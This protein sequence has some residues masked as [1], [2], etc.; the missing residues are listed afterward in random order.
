[1]ACEFQVR[2][3][4]S[5]AENDTEAALAALDAV[6]TI[7]DRLT[8]YRSESEVQTL[9]REAADG[10]AW[11]EPDV[12][13]LLALAER[14][15]ADTGGAFDITSGPLSDTWGFSRRAGRVPTPH[16]IAGALAR[17]GWGGVALDPSAQTVRF[18][19][20]ELRI[21]FNSIGKGFALDAAG[22]VLNRHG[23]GSYLLHGGRSTLLAAGVAPGEPSEQR[24]ESGGWGVGVRHP[25]RPSERI[26]E[27][28]LRNAAF[29]TSG[30][31]TQCFVHAG[32]RYGHLID[33]R[34][35]Q[36]VEGLHSVSV[37]APTGAE[38]DA[39]ST[40]FY[41]MGHEQAAAYCRNRP[42]VQALFV[43]PA[44]GA[45]RVAVRGENLDH[46]CWRLASHYCQPS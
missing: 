21:N 31:A 8:V 42:E 41:V 32:R 35:G 22:D 10:P 36:P 39:L 27:C 13:E 44:A 38:A 26:A 33:P 34:T 6:E 3:P 37:I 4:A 15:H 40:A 11:V 14:L 5:P 23:V 30:S 9:N 43:L 20:P 19:T 24:N 1:M 12:F 7:E 25:L 28:R 46:E 29:S 17:V 18:A 2:L 45:N 16:E